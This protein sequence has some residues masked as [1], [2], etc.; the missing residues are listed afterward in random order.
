[1]IIFQSLL[2]VVFCGR[3]A[4][5]LSPVPR[6]FVASGCGSI[7]LDCPLGSLLVVL[8]AS[9]TPG[10][11]C[12]LGSQAQLEDNWYIWGSVVSR[13]NG[14]RDGS[15]SYNLALELPES[16]LWGDGR[17]DVKFRCETKIAS[18]CGGKLDVSKPGYISS[19]GYP[20]YY[21][22]GRECVW[23]LHAPLGQTV[24]IH[25]LDLSIQG[26]D[27][28]SLIENGETR[29]EHCG[30]LSNTI[31]FSS[32]S[33]QLEL[34]MSTVNGKLF[35][36]RGLLLNYKSAGCSTPPPLHRANIILQNS[37]HTVYH[38][39]DGSL[40]K[41]NISAYKIV[42]CRGSVWNSEPDSCTPIHQLV[43]GAFNVQGVQ[44]VQSVPSV[45]SVHKL[46]R[47]QTLL[48]ALQYAGSSSHR[49][50]EKMSLEVGTTIVLGLLLVFSLVVGILLYCMFKEAEQSYL[51][52][53]Q[54]HL[55]ESLSK[56]V[57]EDQVERY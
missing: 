14:Y 56:E 57:I 49:G 7:N 47:N 22:G 40:F 28:I 10:N 34:R 26:S 48:Q 11:Q 17:I 31:S 38:C 12:S 37:T 53:D 23:N 9:F 27:C 19:P 3:L 36:R 5:G 42:E 6:N 20:R 29:M 52:D 43:Q 2:V 1:M 30:D 50:V 24:Q 25:I 18:F 46:L 44:S 8:Q 55:K 51:Q 35:P 39:E 21:L 13:C 41:S 32:R 4:T 16:R 33:N 45:Q 15:C 54:I